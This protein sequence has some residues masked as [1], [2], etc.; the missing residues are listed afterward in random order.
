AYSTNAIFLIYR[1]S[2]KNS[3]KI[4]LE[5]QTEKPLAVN[6]VATGIDGWLYSKQ[7]LEKVKGTATISN[8]D[9]AFALGYFSAPGGTA[10]YGYLSNFGQLKFPAITYKCVQQTVMLDAG[11]AQ[12]YKWW[13]GLPN[14][15]PSD[16]SPLVLSTSSTYVVPANNPGHYSVKV[17]QD[18]FEVVTTTEVINDKF[19]ATTTVPKY[20][21]K[22][23]SYSF[24]ASVWRDVAK[25][26]FWTIGGGTPPS[27]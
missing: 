17:F 24:G 7:D 4:K 1:E 10:L 26:Y 12:K 2:A 8:A 20:A 6:N 23:N 16:G 13:R 15:E 27:A 3:F 19:E 22:G 9:G 14:Q 21:K 11:Y 5:G 18:P 25:S